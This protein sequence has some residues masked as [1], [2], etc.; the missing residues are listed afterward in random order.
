MEPPSASLNEE[1]QRKVRICAGGWQAMARLK[2]L[3]NPFRQ[4]IVTFLYISHRVLRWSITPA[5]LALLVPMNA[6]L[7]YTQH[8]IYTL[9]LLLQVLFYVSSLVGW[10]LASR[11]RKAGAALVPLYFT[12][13]NVAAFRGFGRFL[14]NSQPAAWDKAQRTT[15]VKV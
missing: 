7:S 13:M 14:Q 5:L 12:M 1:M 6:Y 4:P 9:L 3:L 10:W 2:F 15:A 11:N 8:G